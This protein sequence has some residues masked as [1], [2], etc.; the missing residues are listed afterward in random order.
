MDGRSTCS[1]P[2]LYREEE[3][4][5][6]RLRNLPEGDSADRSVRD[7]YETDGDFFLFVFFKI[8]NTNEYYPR[9]S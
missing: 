9:T 6:C 8:I 7:S 2:A 5:T 1:L 3:E 4:V